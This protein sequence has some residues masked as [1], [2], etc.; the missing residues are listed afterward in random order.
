M[1]VAD[2]SFTNISNLESIR[3]QNNSKR[4]DKRTFLVLFSIIIRII[5]YVGPRSLILSLFLSLT[6]IFR[7]RKANVLPRRQP[8]HFSSRLSTVKREKQ[9]QLDSFNG[10]KRRNSLIVISTR[11]RLSAISSQV[12]NEVNQTILVQLWIWKRSKWHTLDCLPTEDGRTTERKSPFCKRVNRRE[13]SYEQWIIDW[14]VQGESKII[15]ID[16]LMDHRLSINI[17]R[18]FIQIWNSIESSSDTQHR[19]NFSCQRKFFVDSSSTDDQN[20][21][22]RLLS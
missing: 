3:R 15:L 12:T 4:P 20:N 21:S 19:W 17:R 18:F 7:A 6:N 16:S 8:S 5:N 2:W 10:R 9:W 11:C 22:T 14:R 1:F 13:S